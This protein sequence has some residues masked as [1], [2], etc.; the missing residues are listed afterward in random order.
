[1]AGALAAGIADAARNW[2]LKVIGLDRGYER[3]GFRAYPGFCSRRYSSERR[4][5]MAIASGCGMARRSLRKLAMASLD[6]ALVRSPYP[7]T[8][9]RSF[10][11]VERP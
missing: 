4:S 8:R 10:G 5:R 3:P 9:S 11:K 6:N 2:T 1:M 7:L